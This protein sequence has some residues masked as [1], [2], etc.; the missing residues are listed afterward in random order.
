MIILKKIDEKNILDINN[1]KVTELKD[2]DSGIYFIEGNE[3]NSIFWK[4][5][6][7]KNNKLAIILEN[8]NNQNKFY[9]YKN[10]KIYQGNFYNEIKNYKIYEELCFQ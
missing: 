1:Q 2:G 7:L 3:Q 10:G 5:K 8:Y 4:I 6:K 9:I